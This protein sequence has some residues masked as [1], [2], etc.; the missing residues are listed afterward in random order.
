MRFSIKMRAS[1]RGSSLP[2]TSDGASSDHAESRDRADRHI[3][4]AE[5]IVSA[6]DIMR[7][8]AE[9]E[10]RAWTHSNGR[11]DD[12]VVSV[13]RV[14]EDEITHIPAL[15]RETRHTQTVDD[16]HRAITEILGDE[17]IPTAE[18]ALD[19]LTR[20][21]GMRGAMLL[22]ADTG[23]RRDTKDIRGVRV[24]ALDNDMPTGADGAEEMSSSAA[25]KP[26]YCEALT[27][28]S[29]VQYHPAVC[30]E[31]CISDDPE[32]TT[33]YV[34]TPGS[35]V[36]IE[37]IK[38][39]G[40]PQGGRVFLV[41]GTDNEI[42]DC[43]D[44]LENT[45]VIV[46]G[47]PWPP[48]DNHTPNPGASDATA[49][50]LPTDLTTFAE[51]SLAEWE[52][53]GLRR[54]PLEFSSAPT[55]HT[56]VSKSDTVLFS[57]SNYLGLSEHPDVIAAATGALK[58]YG[59]GTGGSRL[60][61]GNFTIH[62]S[63]ERTLAEF[64][65]Y[66]NAVL[67][68]TG[69]QA[70]GAILATLATDIPEAP[71][72]APANTPGMTIF[73]DELNHASLIDGIRMATRGNAEVH[74]YPHKKMEH[75]ENALAQCSSPRKLI[76]SDG[77]FSMNG[78]IAPLPSIMRLARAHGSWVLIDDAHGTG[79]LGRTGRG[80]VEYWND[81]RRQDAGVNSSPGAGLPDDSDLRPDLLVIT[82]SKA[83]GSEG[84]AVCCSTPVAEFLRNRARGYVFST[85]SA[86]AS[87][88]ATQAAVRT[89]LRE[90]E[91]VHRLQENSL[92][93]RNQLREHGIPLVDGTSDSTPIIPIFIGDEADAV[94]ISQGLSDR[95]FHVPGIRY[96][97][98]ARGRAILRVTT[99]ATHTRDDLDRL[100][101]ALRD[102]MPHA[103]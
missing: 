66:D 95:G 30:A 59:A 97:T 32:Y 20:I 10:H 86:P 60:T 33:G 77:V 57:S 12:V 18:H 63:T 5:R 84:A 88:A 62:T 48:Q 58:H 14:D 96:P 11:P 50:D 101:D 78:D 56:T 9:L 24:T 34:S 70:N 76:V 42:A 52:N 98:V 6:S 93:L 21:R 87:V 36:R 51:Q 4:G 44:Y 79:T 85:S 38:P 53:K 47:I 8:V 41:R 39:A 64:T 23:E 68:G 35:Y 17:G 31:L 26:Y 28:A 72:T 74:I 103:T 49:P 2:S 46:H 40:S 16:A 7:T 43:I 37:N 73:S 94:R 19:A 29:K 99:M 83:L 61:T 22:D 55:P 65:G 75:L 1:A 69:Y 100:V 71:S 13:H 25:A 92:Y 81:A 54:Y 15:T 3:S 80:I 90:P 67:F 27:L 102:L 45:P 91:R 89:I 82:A